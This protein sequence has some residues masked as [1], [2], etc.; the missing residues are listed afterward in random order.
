M[1]EGHEKIHKEG[2]EVL[3]T[4]LP[5]KTRAALT[6]RFGESK[7]SARPYRSDPSPPSQNADDPG[8]S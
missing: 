3:L 6:Q 5:R 2:D 4:R 7:T 8:D 1:I